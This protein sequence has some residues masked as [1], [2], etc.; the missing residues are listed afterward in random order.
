MLLIAGFV[1]AALNLRPALAGL[2]PLLGEIMDDLALGP[3]AGGAITTVMV[4][5]LG[6]LGPVAPVLSTRFGLD[7]ALLVGLAVLAAGAVLRSSDGLFGLYGGAV[8]VGTAIAIMNVVMPGLVKQHFPTK[9]GLF[10]GL[11]VSCLVT[12]A[13]TASAIAVPL[14]DQYGWRIAA[15]STAL[16]AVL[17]ALVWIPQAA[18]P[19]PV[20]PTGPRPFR[21]LLRSRVTWYVTL[22][23][24]FQSMSF[25]IML[26]W[27]P[28]IFQDAGLPADQAGYLLSLTNLMQIAATLS[29]PILAGRVRSQA[30]HVTAAAVLTVAGY[31]GVL[32]APAT[33]PWLWMS[34]LGVGQGAS[35]ALALL[36]I[37][38][39][40][41]DP[42]S[43]T[44]LSAIAQSC[45]YLLAALGPFVIGLLNQL[46]GGWT[47]PLVAGLG[48]CVIQL[49]FGLIAGRPVETARAEA[50]IR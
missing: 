30:P 23:M 36:I 40:A 49:V 45:G 9:I 13:A 18:R 21:R 47:W 24:G 26:A 46:T 11:Y 42:A 8:L 19:V 39:R 29:V 31:L 12:G 20:A 33:L 25:Y 1:L 43:V 2:S 3:A 35:I 5:C 48:V 7:R 16:L 28:T 34:I 15:G 17:A 14:A 10:T 44:A 37:T 27:L 4:V 41:P 32:L 38:L 6:L 50:T 22:F